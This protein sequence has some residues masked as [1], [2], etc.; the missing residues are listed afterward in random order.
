MHGAVLAS[1][2]LQIVLLSL[3]TL[4]FLPE[5]KTANLTVCL[6]LTLPLA[7]FVPFIVKRNIRAAAWLSYFIMLY[8]TMATLNVF[9]PRYGVLAQL[10]LSNSILLFIF[11]MMF[12]RYEQR[13]LGISIT[14]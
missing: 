10:E 6:V 8:F 1:L 7:A 3:G 12:T 4:W 2:L 5:G 9:D 14:R 13:R 11:S